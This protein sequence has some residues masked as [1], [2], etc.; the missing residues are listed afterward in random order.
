MIYVF[1]NQGC[2][3]AFI[4]TCCVTPTKQKTSSYYKLT[5]EKQ[6]VNYSPAH[7]IT[8]RSGA[9]LINQTCSELRFWDRLRQKYTNTEPQTGRKTERSPGG[10]GGHGR[11]TVLTEQRKSSQQSLWYS[12][13][14]KHKLIHTLQHWGEEVIIPVVTSAV[15]G[16]EE[17]PLKHQTCI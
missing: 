14:L 5:F 17:F 7:H 15:R 9:A 2:W 12:L 13:S 8:F 10:G 6:F 3:A 11:Q 1:I 16:R 4:V